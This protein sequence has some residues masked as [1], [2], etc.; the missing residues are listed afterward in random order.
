M[1]SDIKFTWVQVGSRRRATVPVKA[2][3]MWAV[4]PAPLCPLASLCSLFSAFL[5]RGA[6][7]QRSHVLA[8]SLFWLCQLRC[9]SHN[10]PTKRTSAAE[11]NRMIPNSSVWRNGLLPSRIQTQ[12]ILDC[13]CGNSKGEK[14]GDPACFQFLKHFRINKIFLHS[15]L[16]ATYSFIKPST[17]NNPENYQKQ[18]QPDKGLHISALFSYILNTGCLYNK[19]DHV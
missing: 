8:E 18:M 1:Q 6:D 15:T 3:V 5:L 4:S 16:V 7:K 2:L 11:V 19:W 13:H 14:K 12:M 9:F 10:H 17:V